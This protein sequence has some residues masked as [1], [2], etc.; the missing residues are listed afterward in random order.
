MCATGFDI[1]LSDSISKKASSILECLDCELEKAVMASLDSIVDFVVGLSAA[2]ID[3][4]L[5]A[6]AHRGAAE[7]L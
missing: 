1:D 2:G 5:E 7:I 6:A 4:P 3:C